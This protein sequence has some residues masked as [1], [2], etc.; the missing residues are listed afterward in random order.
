LLKLAADPKHLGAKIG[1]L[2]TLH[3]WGQNLRLHPHVHCVVTG[4]GL[5]PDES[6]WITGSDDFFLPFQ[7]LSRV[8]RGKFVAGLRNLFTRGQLHFAD[9]L[10]MRS[11]LEQFNHLLSESV[12]SDWVVHVKPPWGGPRTVLKYLARYTHKTAISNHRLVSLQGG[13]VCFRWKDYAH[14][15]QRRIMKL[16]AIEFVRRFL[17]HVLPSG[18]VRVRHYGILANRLRQEKLALCRELLGIEPTFQDQEDPP[19]PVATPEHDSPVSP[20]KV[21]PVCRAG[22]MTVIEDFR[23]ITMNP[24]AFK[25]TE[26]CLTFNTS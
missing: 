15:R 4:G 22:R 8:F 3:T 5:S 1:V 24:Q 20:T 7:I 25:Q 16:S 9:K 6:R 12:R 19:V 11:R 21:C 17:M 26:P 23:P 18:F 2:A 13:Q 10:T 14:D